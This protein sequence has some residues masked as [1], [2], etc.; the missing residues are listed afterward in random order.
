MNLPNKLTFLR[1]VLIPFVM[2]F[3]MMGV[4]RP[5]FMYIAFALFVI[6]C[7]TDF[8]DGYIARKYNLVTNLG[9]FMDPIADKLLIICTLI[10]FVQIGGCM[11]YDHVWWVLAL[12]VAR[13]IAIT[14]F[15]TIAAE[16][17]VVIAA[18]MYGKLKTNAQ[19]FWTIFLILYMPLKLLLPQNIM[20]I[21]EIVTM[22]LLGL[23]AFLT[24]LS[25]TIYLIQNKKV[26]KDNEDK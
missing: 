6:A 11:V 13:E 3:I 14:G 9:K 5:L 16:R 18:N 10:C 7:L 4:E 23:T 20:F 12:I 15:R 26:L 8:L 17:G 22:V 1:I 21:Y 25:F 19:M 2:L 24:I